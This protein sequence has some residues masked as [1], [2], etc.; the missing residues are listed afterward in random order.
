MR[1]AWVCGFLFTLTFINY[2]ERVALSAAA[3][4][5]SAEFLLSP[6]EKGVLVVICATATLRMARPPVEVQQQALRHAARLPA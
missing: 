2:T 3:K 6:V 5:I 1:R 4:P